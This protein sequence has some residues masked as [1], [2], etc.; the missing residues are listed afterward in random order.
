MHQQELDTALL[1]SWHIGQPPAGL[2]ERIAAHALSRK[3]LPAFWHTPLLTRLE[4]AFSDWHTQLA[5]KMV[6]LALCAFLGFG[7]GMMRGAN[8]TAVDISALALGD[9]QGD[10]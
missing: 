1:H 8:E 6:A 4:S 10:W 9:T 2:E 5:Y 7:S 3:Q